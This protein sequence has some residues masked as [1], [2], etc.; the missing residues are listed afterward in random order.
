MARLE[1]TGISHKSLP[2]FVSKPEKYVAALAFVES[3]M[4]DRI[5]A[6]KILSNAAF[7]EWA[8]YIERD[9]VIDIMKIKGRL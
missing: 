3:G 7:N 9:P 8:G 4:T 5:A 1:D 2:I 6:E